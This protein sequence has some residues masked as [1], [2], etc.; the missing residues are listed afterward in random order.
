MKTKE[1][2]NKISLLAYEA[3]ISL[4]MDEI[5]EFDNSENIKFIRRQKLYQRAALNKEKYEILATQIGDK[6][7]EK[8]ANLVNL[9]FE[10]LSNIIVQ[11]KPN[12]QF[13][14]LEKLE[15]NE[16]RELIADLYMLEDIENEDSES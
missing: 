14:N 4:S 8:I 7:K 13:R 6:T 5:N 3:S 10:Q 16:L 1:I 11:D 2:L 12:F 15:E 9:S